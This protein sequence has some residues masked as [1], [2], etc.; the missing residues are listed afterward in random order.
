MKRFRRG[1]NSCVMGREMG[2]KL[3]IS[4]DVTAGGGVSSV[5]YVLKE[6]NCLYTTDN[7]TNNMH[8]IH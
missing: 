1:F 5:L 3:P 7:I 6:C 4:E 2:G 8:K